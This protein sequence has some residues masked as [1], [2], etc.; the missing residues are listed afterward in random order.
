MIGLSLMID[1]NINFENPIGLLLFYFG[2][3]L[4][5]FIWY[6]PLSIFISSGVKLLK[7]KL[8]KYILIISGLFMI[9]IGLYLGGSIIIFPPEI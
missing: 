9:I 2:H 6:V 8:Y 7:S 1:F 3:I 4:G 5:D